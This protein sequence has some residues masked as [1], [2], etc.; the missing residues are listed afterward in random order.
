MIPTEK[1]NRSNYTSWSYKMHQYLL[2]HGYWSYVDG[3]NDVAPEATHMDS[4]AWEQAASRVMYC[5]ASVSPIN[6]SD[7]SETRRRRRRPG[8]I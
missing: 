5:F 6:C 7:I 3:A 4:S 1:L 2:E 8:K